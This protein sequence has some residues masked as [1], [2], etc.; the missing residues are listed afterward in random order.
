MA[1][2]I[3]E[4]PEFASDFTGG[5]VQDAKN[6]GLLTITAVVNGK[7]DSSI[8]QVVVNP[9]DES[10]TDATKEIFDGKDPAPRISCADDIKDVV[11]DN[12]QEFNPE[13]E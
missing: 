3:P 10:I 6:G 7:V 2:T 11:E 9:E 5:Y 12:I 1:N 4:F 8:A 13:C